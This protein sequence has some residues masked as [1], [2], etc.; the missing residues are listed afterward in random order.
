MGAR[1]RATFGCL[2]LVVAVIVA[3]FASLRGARADG[4]ADE[5]DL[6]FQLA[7]RAA[8]QRGEFRGALEHFLFSNRLVPNRNVVFNIART[9]EQ[10]KR[11]A[12]AHRYY[13]DALEGET[14]EADDSRHQRRDRAHRAQRRR[15]PRRDRAARR[16]HL[17]RSQGPR[18]ARPRPAAAGAA[19]RASTT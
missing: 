6:H 12:D 14:N 9:Y 3:T 13:V 10:L 1:A 4:V 17:H 5:A 2:L 11:Y 7:R 15:A 18:L 19:P 8:T 16:D